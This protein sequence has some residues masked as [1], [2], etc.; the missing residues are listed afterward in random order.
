MQELNQVNG[1]LKDGLLFCKKA[2]E[3]FNIIR[4]SDGGIER[5]R[6]RKNDVEKKLVEEVLPIARYIQMKYN[7]SKNIKVKWV[8]GSQPYDAY[9]QLSGPEVLNSSIPKK[10][11]LEVTTAVH[12]NDHLAR[13]FANKFGYVFGINGVKIN[14][15]TKKI[16]STPHVQQFQKALDDFIDII[17]ARIKDKS[18]KIYPN[19]TTLVIQCMLSPL[20]VRSE[21]DYI[22]KKVRE[23]GIMHKFREIV[24]F[25]LNNMLLPTIL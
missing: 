7:Y 3:I 20:F 18:N 1:R 25:D 4:N 5:L 16:E 12:N 8:Y 10:Q 13:E 24:L 22:V 6:L 9:I 2:Y 14:K 21:W 11:Y 23:A 17:I 15:D 19:N